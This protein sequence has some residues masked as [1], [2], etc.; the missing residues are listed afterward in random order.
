MPRVLIIDD[1]VQL[2]RLLRIALETRGYAVNDAA[3]GRVGIET[4]AF[5]QPD[6]VILDLGLPDLDGLS[7]LQRIRVFSDVPVLVLSVRSREE[8]KVAALDAG[9]DDF[10]TKPFGMNELAARLSA[11]LRRRNQ[12]GDIALNVGGLSMDLVH[13][14]A[15][16]N[17]TPLTLTP[18][19]FAILSELCA[20]EGRLVTQASISAK[21]WPTQQSDCS[22]VLRVHLTHLRKKLSPHECRIINVPG[23]GYRIEIPPSP[24]SAPDQT[25]K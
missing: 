6:I 8:V 16:F 23:V 14:E 24:D 11:L 10:V 4:V 1:E 15:T 12:G 9:A 5:W 21:V 19:E 25:S 20:H 18:T 13:R 22:E 7:V 17:G 3:F 2:R